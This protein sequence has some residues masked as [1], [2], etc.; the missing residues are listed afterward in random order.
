ME[1]ISA[2]T[3]IEHTLRITAIMLGHTRTTGTWI[4]SLMQTRGTLT[5]LG[6]LIRY[7]ESLPPSGEQDSQDA[8]GEEESNPVG[9]ELLTIAVGNL[10]A[11]TDVGTGIA[12]TIAMLCEFCVELVVSDLLL[13][14]IDL[15]PGCR[16]RAE[17]L[18]LCYCVNAEPFVFYLVE[19]Y[20]ESI[21]GGLAV[22]L[23]SSQI[24][25]LRA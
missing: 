19:L 8:G 21:Q 13:T 24:G 16:N 6:R 1:L 2:V 4:I 14:L 17:C 3:I 20:T 18:R 10:T 22:S 7:R 25:E 5:A 9:Q 15:G 23:F 12:M 11:C